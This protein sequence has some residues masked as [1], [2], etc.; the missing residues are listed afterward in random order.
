MK[1]EIVLEI[2]KSALMVVS[3]VSAAGITFHI[4]EKKLVEFQSEQA[5]VSRFREIQYK[6]ANEVLEQANKLLVSAISM[7][8]IGNRF[9]EFKKL[10][11][12]DQSL[13]VFF[14]AYS[15][16]IEESIPFQDNNAAGEYIGLLVRAKYV[17]GTE[18]SD[19]FYTLFDGFASDYQKAPKL[20][21]RIGYLFDKYQKQGQLV[22]TD[23][24]SLEVTIAATQAMFSPDVDIMQENYKELITIMGRM[25]YLGVNPNI[26]NN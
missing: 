15:D 1:R 18:T 9:K 21:D 19:S 16:L 6:T 20:L 26:P 8:M 22:G 3:L 11:P 17:L 2:V 24:V 13:E 23:L 10:G 14:L 4:Y 25:G 5:K 12:E 7:D